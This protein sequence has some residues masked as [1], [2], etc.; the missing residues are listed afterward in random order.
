MQGK[1]GF[2]AFSF[3]NSLPQFVFWC[4]VVPL[5][6]APG[7]GDLEEAQQAFLSEAATVEEFL[8]LV[9][10]PQ[11]LEH[12]SV[13]MKVF[14][15]LF[16]RDLKTFQAAVMLC[17][18]APRLE[19]LPMIGRRIRLAF[20]N[21]DTAKRKSILQLV[22]SDPGRLEDLRVVTLLSEAL[23][24]SDPSLAELAL[25]LVQDHPQ[26]E[27]L[28]AISE[29]LLQVSPNGFTPKL[30]LPLFSLFLDRILPLLEQTGSDDKSCFNCHK[31]HFVFRLEMPQSQH[32]EDDLRRYYTAALRVIDLKQPKR[33]LLLVKPTQEKPP[34][35]NLPK[36]PH[37][38]GGGV[39]WKEGSA[40]Y[41][42]LMEWVQTGSY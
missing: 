31:S 21:K 37:E 30:N 18:K 23:V 20:L 11:L 22:R 2:R 15:S 17:L 9:S 12:R 6:G 32:T 25:S 40:P 1:I 33:S 27:M 34:G 39:R 42:A 14:R 7:P 41:Q 13:Q 26:L 5:V 28:P 35:R 3:S 16:S 24:D 10:F 8:N 29:S 4:F 38:H 19:S 36:G